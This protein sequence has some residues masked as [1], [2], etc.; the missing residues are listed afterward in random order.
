LN[1]PYFIAKRLRINENHSF[2][3][4]IIHIAIAGVALGFAVVVVAMATVN[5]FQS[6]IS[7]KVAGFGG[8]IE[9]HK[10]GSTGQY[11]YPMF[12]IPNG[13]MEQ[14]L[15]FE[16]V[17]SVSPVANKPGMIKSG[18]ELLGIIFKGIDSAYKRDFYRE[19][20]LEGR[21][22]QAPGEMMISE[23]MAEKLQLKTGDKGKVYFIREPVRA[24]APRLVGIYKTGLEEYDKLYAFGSITDVQRIFS[25]KKPLVTHLEISLY[26]ME[27]T[28]RLSDSIFTLL[29]YDLNL[30][31]MYESHPHIFQWL[32]Y[33]DLN[34]YII[35]SLMSFVC[36]ICLVTALLILVVERTNM[37]GIL[38]TLG[39]GNA[40]IKQIFLYKITYITG[41]GMGLGNLLG[42][43]LMLFQRYT[44]WL[45]LD[46]ET[47]FI[48][49][50]P[51]EFDIWTIVWTNVICFI[52]CVLALLIP[53]Q[54]VTGIQP[55]KSVRF[56]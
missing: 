32:K 10:T 42:L 41:I 23:Y 19:Y 40:L 25:Q 12:D 56:E 52:I 44:G 21:L 8:E 16:G 13:L 29:D 31:N 17:K 48:S 51:V 38:K 45:T 36:S 5:G 47:Y 4:K 54:W 35:L 39:A 49:T 26:R 20:L 6:E 2:V 1:L 33:L 3:G 28:E 18:D 15:A 46:Q 55:A 50:V 43:G 27:D 24:I 53:V 11:D 30:R 14:M 7:R 22:P 34:K 9:V 37:I